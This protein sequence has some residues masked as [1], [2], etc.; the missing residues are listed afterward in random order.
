[1]TDSTPVRGGTERNA[2]TIELFFDLVYVFA[3]TLALEHLFPWTD[4]SLSE[5]ST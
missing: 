5:A 3:I 1:M 2:S 4:L